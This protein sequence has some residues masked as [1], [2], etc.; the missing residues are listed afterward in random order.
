MA[1]LF[2]DGW[3]H[4]NTSQLSRKWSTLSG[5]PTIHASNGRFGSGCLEFT[6]TNQGL[7]RT[8]SG[9]ITSW[10][11]GFAFK[12]AALTNYRMVGLRDA[13]TLQC[14]LRLNSDGT[15]SVTR[16]G[17]NVS[18][19]TSAA[20]LSINTYYYIEFKVTIA[21]SI[22]ASSCK[23]RINGTDVITVTTGQDL[24]NTAN[25]Y[26][27]EIILGSVGSS[28]GATIDFDDLY[29]LDNSGS[30]N[31]DFLGDMRVETLYPNGNGNSSQFVGSDSNSTD[32][33]LL[34]DESP[35][36]DD[37][38]YVESST[39]ND[40]DLY[41]FGNLST[42]P[43]SI[44]GTQMVILARKTDAGV[45]T[46]APMTRVASTDYTGSNTNLGTS[47]ANIYEIRE[48]DPNTTVAWIAAGVNGAE[49]GYKLIA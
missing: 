10:V 17:T 15:L 45:R 8:M 42:T 18:G 37:T 30:V 33:Y 21:D 11:V 38:D 40:I 24:K 43:L 4:Y 16:N 44:A 6:N 48:V 23:V 7:A 31:N 47:F 49:F 32:N 29:I 26:A 36:N 28:G 25:A 5:S 13:G 46:V 2:I 22:S 35:A 19:G 39:P 12:I 14:E 27:N 34:V 41:T 3:D 20:T 9:N 1:L